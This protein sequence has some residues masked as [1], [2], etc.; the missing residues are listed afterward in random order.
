MFNTF[1]IGISHSCFSYTSRLML[2]SALKITL[3][4]DDGI[5]KRIF[6]M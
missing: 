1:H 6:Y 3:K 2:V 5:G 4:L